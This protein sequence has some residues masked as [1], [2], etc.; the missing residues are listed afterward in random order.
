VI[1]VTRQGRHTPSVIDIP[2]PV[3]EESTDLIVRITSLLSAAP[4]F[5]P[6]TSL[7]RTCARGMSSGTPTAQTDVRAQLPKQASLPEAWM[8]SKNAARTSAEGWR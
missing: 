1:A 5:T 3:V 6:T 4:T 7:G 2:D 8:P